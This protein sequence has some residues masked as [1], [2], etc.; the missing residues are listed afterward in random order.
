M[1]KDEIFYRVLE[2]AKDKTTSEADLHV[3]YALEYNYKTE[4]DNSG[5]IPSVHE[6][7]LH[8][9]ANNQ[10][11][12][13]DVGEAYEYAMHL[14]AE[15]VCWQEWADKNFKE[16]LKNYKLKEKEKEENLS[17]NKQIMSKLS[18]KELNEIMDRQ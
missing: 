3:L 5:Y 13:E 17:H 12:V 18:R 1:T 11:D 8:L 14:H 7:A 16:W 10:R 15:G 9:A 6:I 2:L 4:Q